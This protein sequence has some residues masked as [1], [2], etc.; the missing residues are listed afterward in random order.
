M[1]VLVQYLLLFA[2]TRELQGSFEQIVNA[3]PNN[4]RQQ[5][6]SIVVEFYDDLEIVCGR[7]KVFRLLLCVYPMMVMLRLFKSFA[8]Q[9]R[10]AIVTS[11]LQ[12]AAQDMI[13][14]FI[15]FLSVTCCL[16]LNAVLFF[17]QDLEDFG[18]FPR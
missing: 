7:E 3:K 4:G 17:G 2:A 12:E 14:F 10:L 13:H 18:T 8:A 5:F 16:T 15:V 9:A 1:S 11:T 6:E